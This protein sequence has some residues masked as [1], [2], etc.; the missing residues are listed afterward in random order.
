MSKLDKTSIRIAQDKEI[1]SFVK[2][3]YSIAT[4]GS[5][6]G[7]NPATI[8]KRLKI[9]GVDII[10]NRKSFTEDIFEKLSPQQKIWLE[11]KLTP[12]YN[13]TAFMRDLIIQEFI[14]DRGDK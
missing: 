5:L 6:M 8:T 3:G 14:K 12:V 9:L 10:D 11:A 2:L 4:I 7:V 1:L 13:V